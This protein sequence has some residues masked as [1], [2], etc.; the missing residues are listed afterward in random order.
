MI[1]R[2]INFFLPRVTIVRYNFADNETKTTA[3]Q[4][5]PF[6]LEILVLVTILATLPIMK[7]K[8]WNVSNTYGR[9]YQI[10]YATLMS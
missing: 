10:I 6:G 9:L 1:W 4:N 2:K 8:Q 7:P 5:R 3:A